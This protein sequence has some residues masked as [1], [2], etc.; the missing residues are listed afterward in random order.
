MSPKTSKQFEEIRQSRKAA[1]VETALE[2]FANKGFAGIS[3]S[4]IAQKAGISKG[5]LYNY[6][7]N[8]ESLVR[9]II[10]EGFRQMLKDLD[11]DFQQELTKKRFIELIHKNFDMLKQNTNYLKLYTA[12]I[13]Q[14]AVMALV[15]EE[16]FKVAEP[17]I[18]SITAYYQ[19]KGVQN[20]LAYGYLIWA[21]IDGIELDYMFDPEHYPLEEI[22][23][24]IIEKFV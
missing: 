5:L 15:K 13:T 14:P 6:F 4:N 19:K 23:N 24:I 16:V 10:L 22:R 17:F 18:I 21:I 2:L 11:F 20:P 9:E 12:V 1:I 3:I 7:E 8:K